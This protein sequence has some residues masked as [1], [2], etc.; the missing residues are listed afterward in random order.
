MSFFL[1]SRLSLG[2]ILSLFFRYKMSLK[3]NID[4][5]QPMIESS[6]NML[7]YIFSLDLRIGCYR[8]KY[9]LYKKKSF[10]IF[11]DPI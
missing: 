7:K 10:S 1:L 5:T 6:L 2:K 3:F 8:M 4:S 9:A 11:I